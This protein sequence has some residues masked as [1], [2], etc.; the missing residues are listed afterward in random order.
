MR[1]ERKKRWVHIYICIYIYLYIFNQ[2]FEIGPLMF[3]SLLAEA[4]KGPISISHSHVLTH[5][6]INTHI[7]NTYDIYIRI[8]IYI[9][10]CL[11]LPTAYCLWILHTAYCHIAYFYV[12]TSP[13]SVTARTLKLARTGVILTILQWH[14]PRHDIDTTRE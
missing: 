1:T 9:A 11:F 2:S 6:F 14:V 13:L 10:Y 4:S 3:C 7:L 12:D 8:Y 5:V